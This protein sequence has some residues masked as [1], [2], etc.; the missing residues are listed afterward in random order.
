LDRF[1]LARKAGDRLNARIT[2]RIHLGP[3]VNAIPTVRIDDLAPAR[4]LAEALSAWHGFAELAPAVLGRASMPYWVL[5][6]SPDETWKA[7]R[8]PD[9]SLGPIGCWLLRDLELSGS[10]YLFQRGRL[11]REF[12]NIADA[13]LRQ[14]SDPGADDNPLHHPRTNRVVIDEPALLVCGPGWGTYGH[15]LLDFMPRI[16]LAQQLLGSALDDFVLPLPL[17]SPDWV[18]RMIQHFCGIDPGRVR[19]Y[20][21]YDDLLVCRRACVPCYLHDGIYAPHPL[22]RAFYEQFGNPGAARRKRRICISRRNQEGHGVGSLR[23]FEARETMEQM[24]VA[25]D[26]EIVQPETLSFPEQVELFRSANCILGEHGS[27]MHS[28]VFADPGTVVAVVRSPQRAHQLKLAAAFEHQFICMNR[29]RVTE[30]TV[31]APSRFTASEADL[32]TLLDMIDAV[33]G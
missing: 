23:K 26:F 22:M 19:H 6:D 27:G 7:E 25:R 4:P 15:W 1:L 24:A 11:V 21:R 10:G 30:G 17:D 31:S 14:L 2:E 8:T 28:A 16:F 33:Q 9:Y 12:G 32:T 18:V 3:F 13:V 5:R 20:S 29:I